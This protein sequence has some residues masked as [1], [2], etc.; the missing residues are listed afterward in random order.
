MELSSGGAKLFMS[1]IRLIATNYALRCDAKFADEDVLAIDSRIRKGQF[2]ELGEFLPLA[3][4]KGIQPNYLDQASEDSVPV[5][6]TLSIQNLSLNEENCRHITRDDFDELTEDR[7]LK[8]GDV[9]LTVD[10]GVSIGKPFL[11]DRDDD[12]SLDSHVVALR[13][14]GI[15]PLAVVYLLASPLGQ[16]QFR[17]AESGASGQTTVTE[18]DIRRF[19]FPR[20]ILKTIDQV[21][22]KIEKERGQIATQRIE[23]AKREVGLWQELEKFVA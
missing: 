7:K 1:S 22:K 19:V 10:G 8:R 18:D 16:T 21:A 5:V 9:L 15:S 20:S 23:L 11:F 13:P 4:A 2:F 14:T 6:N 3:F 12:F 17:R